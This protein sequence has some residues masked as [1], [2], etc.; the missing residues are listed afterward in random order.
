ML[1]VTSFALILKVYLISKINYFK[2]FSC[3]SRKITKIRRYHLLRRK[4]S[5]PRERN[6][7]L[8]RTTQNQNTMKMMKKQK[9]KLHLMI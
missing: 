3:S 8:L 7:R 5:Q 2:S 4:R 9:K 1:K 6:P